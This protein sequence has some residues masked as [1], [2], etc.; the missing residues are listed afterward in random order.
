MYN[1]LMLKAAQSSPPPP[2]N[3]DELLQAKAYLKEV[4]DGSNDI[5]TFANN[6]VKY[7]MKSFSI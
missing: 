1:P 4:F 3:F 6:S 5:Q 2:D 7:C